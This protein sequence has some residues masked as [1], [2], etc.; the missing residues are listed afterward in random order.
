MSLVMTLLLVAYQVLYVEHQ[1]GM[2]IAG[3]FTFLSPFHVM[4]DVS[5]W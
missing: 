1:S 3:C 5:D 4:I 2:I